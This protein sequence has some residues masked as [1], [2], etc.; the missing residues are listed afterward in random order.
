M[1]SA[2]GLGRSSSPTATMSTRAGSGRVSLLPTSL[3]PGDGMLARER[4]CLRLAHRTDTYGLHSRQE[5]A[6]H[7]HPTS[8]RLSLASLSRRNSC[9]KVRRDCSHS[10]LSI[11]NPL[12]HRTGE[13]VAARGGRGGHLCDLRQAGQRFQRRMRRFRSREHLDEVRNRY[14]SSTHVT[15]DISR[16][17]RLDVCPL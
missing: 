16:P 1:A 4:V 11:A 15:S 2:G 9:W 3:G 6:Q 14:C 13:M 7:Q 5:R 10:P 12:F 8:S 17:Q